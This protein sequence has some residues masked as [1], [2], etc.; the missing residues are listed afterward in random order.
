MSELTRAQ[1]DAIIRAVLLIRYWGSKAWRPQ[2]ARLSPEKRSELLKLGRM[3]LD[4]VEQEEA[5]A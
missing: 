1:E 5:S 2:L 3:V 4:A